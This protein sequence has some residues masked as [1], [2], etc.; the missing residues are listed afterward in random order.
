V[1]VAPLLVVFEER[2][3]GRGAGGQRIRSPSS[4]G[5]LSVRPV[6]VP[7]PALGIMRNAASLATAVRA[8]RPVALAALAPG[9]RLPAPSEAAVAEVA[10]RVRARAGHDQSNEP[11]GWR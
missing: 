8:A 6:P 3:V 2:P 4:H 11:G 5:R 10:G 7:Y 9:A 1:F